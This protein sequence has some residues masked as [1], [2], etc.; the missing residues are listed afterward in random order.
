VWTLAWRVS[1]ETSLLS[2]RIQPPVASGKRAL[3]LLVSCD[4]GLRDGIQK[5]LHAHRHTLVCASTVET[6][7]AILRQA[8]PHLVIA[9][10]EEDID[11]LRPQLAPS[12]VLLSLSHGAQPDPGRTPPTTLTK[13]FQP[14]ELLAVVRGLRENAGT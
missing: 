5:T 14:E 6:A 9:D 3:V 13:P 1:S 11:S 8:S 12:T 10:L 7:C 4:K 2:P